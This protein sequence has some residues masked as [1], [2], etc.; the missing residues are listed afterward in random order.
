[1][2]TD[3]KLERLIVFERGTEPFSGLPMLWIGALLPDVPFDPAIRVEAYFDGVLKSWLPLRRL[4]PADD[5]PDPGSGFDLQIIDE[6]D[7]KSVR[8]VL[9]LGKKAETL[10]ERRMDEV[11]R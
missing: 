8:V 3:P 2:K 9:R 10:A 4:E 6:P 11:H 7:V 1:M 5:T